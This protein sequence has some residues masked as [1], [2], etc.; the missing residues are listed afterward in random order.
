ME[1]STSRIDIYRSY[2]EMRIRWLEVRKLSPSE[3]RHHKRMAN[4]QLEAYKDALGK[5]EEVKKHE[6]LQV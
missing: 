1:E 3:S 4:F 5:Y 2:L 6:S